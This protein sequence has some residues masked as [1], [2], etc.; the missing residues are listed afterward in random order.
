MWTTKYWHLERIPIDKESRNEMILQS[1]KLFKL[2]S[3]PEML[4]KFYT[5][6]PAFNNIAN[7]ANYVQQ[8]EPVIKDKGQKAKTYCYCEKENVGTTMIARTM[9]NVKLNGSM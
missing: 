1:R 8:I 5:R 9:L 2:R 6:R 4:G 7:Q 3:L